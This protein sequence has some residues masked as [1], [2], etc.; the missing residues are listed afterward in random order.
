MRPAGF[1]PTSEGLEPSILAKLYYGPVFIRK[2][3]Q[4]KNIFDYISNYYKIF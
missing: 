2:L 1:E 3:S 4:F